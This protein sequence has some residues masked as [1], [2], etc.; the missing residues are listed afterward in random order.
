MKRSRK[1]SAPRSAIQRRALRIEQ[2]DK[3]PLYV[4]C[5]T[6]DEILAVADISRLSR[7][8]AG[9]LIGYQRP[10][11]KRHIQD[12][13]EYLNSDN[14]LFPNSLILALSSKVRFRASRGPVVADGLVTAGIVEIPLTKNGHKPAWIVDGQQRALAISKSNR[15][16]LPVP[17]NAFVADEVELQRDQFL[18]VNNTKPLPRGL[19]TELLPEVSTPLPAN[20]QAKK[21]PSALC[22]LL[23]TEP[24]SPFHK[25]ISRASTP[26]QSKRTAVVAD[27]SIIK[28]LQ[29]SLANP[30]G[31]LFP[32]RNI[33]TG[34]TDFDAI[35]A[36]LL[37]YWTAVKKTFPEAWGKPPTKS[38]L[39]HGA[40]IRAM[41]K[42]MDRVMGSIDP[43]GHGVVAH[44]QHELRS[45]QSVCHWTE[46]CW[47]ELGN[48]N[49]N[50]I[51]NVPRHIRTLS[52]ILVRTYVQSRGAR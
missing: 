12:I 37:A 50:E 41:G 39:M 30:S 15:R 5:L 14:I 24:H 38:R 32:Y 45:I 44:V 23:N 20:L 34:E 31:C 33:A 47:S 51:Q 19:I 52:N 9:K 13:V 18:R 26:Q 36:T 27:T 25:L 2:N 46:G 4:F 8:D 35:W 40:G 11:V 21:I 49:W 16:D 17:I 48:L 43:T 6:G 7:N 1:R 42:L 22:D 28:M 10:H 3:H 29:E